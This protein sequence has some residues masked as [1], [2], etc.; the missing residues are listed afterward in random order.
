MDLTVEI[1]IDKIDYLKYDESQIK[2]NKNKMYIAK[3]SI[4]NN[5]ITTQLYLMIAQNT[6][7]KCLRLEII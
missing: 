5:K 3:S 7:I 6:Q 2:V 4:D 1:K